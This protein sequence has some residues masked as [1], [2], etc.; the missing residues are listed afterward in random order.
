MEI[1]SKIA[2]L[3]LKRGKRDPGP[4]WDPQDDKNIFFELPVYEYPMLG[5]K[6]LD[7]SRIEKKL[8]WPY[9]MFHRHF[10]NGAPSDSKR[11][12]FSKLRFI[13]DFTHKMASGDHWDP[14]RWQK[15][16]FWVPRIWKPYGRKKDFWIISHRKKVGRTI[17]SAKPPFW[18]LADMGVDRTEIFRG[19]H[20]FSISTM[21]LAI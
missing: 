20:F 4:N 21:F 2:L 9:P 14:P 8:A 18:I 10:E 1:S 13:S 7:L 11:R 15:L 17:S 6:F 16:F 19:T 5:K 12:F 3:T